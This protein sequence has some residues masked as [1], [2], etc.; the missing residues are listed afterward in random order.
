M[1][2]YF[3]RLGD[4]A[5]L[6][7]DLQTHSVHSVV[8]DAPYGIHIIGE[9]WD[10]TLPEKK[11]W[12]ECFRVLRPGGFCLVFA[13]ARLYHRL[14]CDLE[15]VGFEIH[16]CLCWGYATGAPRPYNIDKALDKYFGVE[17]SDGFPYE[18]KSEEAKK[19][20]G[21]ANILKVGWEPIC[22]ARK[23]I[24]KNLVHNVLTYKVGVLN[25]DE[26]RIPYMSEEDKQSLYSFKHFEE[27]DYGDEKFF[28][29]NSGGKKQCNVHPL[30][31]WPANLLWLDPMF[32]E[33]D[34]Y[35]MVPKPSKNEKGSYNEH[36]TVKPIRL[37]ERLVKMVTPKP[38]MINEDVHVLDPF[39]GSGS[40]GV[41]CKILG[42]HFIGFE[43]DE[44]S[45]ETAKRRLSQR[46]MGD[47]FDR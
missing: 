20:Q 11:I 10:K 13:H 31:R 17:I 9:N 8:T 41:A 4:S 43:K 39:M 7:K 27:G 46:R 44:N 12:E 37:M 33:Y 6:V 25:I 18:P 14:A 5:E 42:R 26:C 22:M 24:E 34:K 2:N 3:L 38:S 19:W 40:T 21:W 28:S 1:K 36:S 23:P 15:D 29:A 32:A 35:F 45:F 16:D 30:G 47:I